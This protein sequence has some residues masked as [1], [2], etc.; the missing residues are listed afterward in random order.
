MIKRLPGERWR[1]Y[2]YSKQVNKYLVSTFGRIA[3]YMR[4]GSGKLR[5][6]EP[7]EL[8]G[9]LVVNI[10]R[11]HAKSRSVKINVIV[12]ETFVGLKPT[13]DNKYYVCRH[14]N[15]NKHDNRLSN[16]RWGTQKQNV[17]DS[18]KHGVHTRGVNNGEAKLTE[19]DIIQIY[20]DP[21]FAIDIAPDYGMHVN[22]I[23]KL[24]RGETY[25]DITSKLTRLP[26]RGPRS[27]RHAWGT[28]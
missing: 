8:D 1:Y 24:L 14:K 28:A 22:A 4:E 16:L 5:L 18:I 10:Q 2:P 3:G 17:Q 13:H 9:Y 15:G 11:K 7:I 25:V 27:T 23:R 12:L 6:I 20:K 19:K 21:R 26:K